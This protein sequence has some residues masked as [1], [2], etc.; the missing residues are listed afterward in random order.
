ME[1]MG[2]TPMASYMEMGV[3]Y[4]WKNK[5]KCAGNYLPEQL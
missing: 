3:N 4:Q 1:I 5:S 2:P